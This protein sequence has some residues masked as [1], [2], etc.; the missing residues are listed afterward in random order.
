VAKVRET[1]AVSEQ[2]VHRFHVER[3]NHKKLNEV[4]DNEQYLAEISNRFAALVNL[5]AEVD[6]NTDWETIRP[7]IKISATDGIGYYE[8]KKRKP[9]FE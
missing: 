5:D 9:W 7:N 3:I 1:L 4:E 8:L 6:I 2:T